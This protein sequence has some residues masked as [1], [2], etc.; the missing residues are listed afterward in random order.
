M[1]VVFALLLLGILCVYCHKHHPTPGG[2][3]PP[4]TDASPS[5]VP[6]APAQK[7]HN[8]MRVLFDGQD[9]DGFLFDCASTSSLEDS[10]AGCAAPPQHV[11][12]TNS[13]KVKQL[14]SRKCK[15]DITNYALLSIKELTHK[16]NIEVSS[17]DQPH[18][19]HAKC[20]LTWN[21]DSYLAGYDLKIH[22]LWVDHIEVPFIEVKS[23]E[24]VAIESPTPLKQGDVFLDSRELILDEKINFLATVLSLSLMA[25]ALTMCCC[26]CTF[27]ATCLCFK[28]CGQKSRRQARDVEN[29]ELEEMPQGK[30]V[31]ASAPQVPVYIPYYMINPYSAPMFTQQNGETTYVMPNA[32]QQL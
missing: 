19:H 18:S 5:P 10:P 28:A 14:C 1:K 8:R 7:M 32:P 16:V 6:V 23:C 12:A 15:L 9:H 26:A 25:L 20:Q 4:P 3:P 27:C 22:Y 17:Y 29:M 21:A 11:M 30:S 31:D 13:T 24:A 2:T